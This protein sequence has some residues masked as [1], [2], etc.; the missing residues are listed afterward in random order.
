MKNERALFRALGLGVITAIVVFAVASCETGATTDPIYHTVMFY[1]SGGSVI[2]P[3]QVREGQPLAIPAN[4]TRGYDVFAGWYTNAEFTERFNQATL[5]TGPI[6]LF[7]RWGVHGC[8]DAGCSYIDCECTG[9]PGADCWC[10]WTSTG[11]KGL[12]FTRSG[13]GY[14]VTGFTGT[15]TDVVIPPIHNE[16]AVVAIWNSAFYENHLINIIIP[17]SVI[18]IGELAFSGNLLTSVTIPGSVTSIGWGA[19]SWNQLTSVTIPD[20]VTSIGSRAFGFNRL[21]NVT[22]SDSVTHLSGFTG[23][24]LTS[25]TIPD[26]VTS[27]GDAA[28]NHNQ[29]TSVTIPDGV[30]SIGD[31]AFG[32]NLLTSVTIPDSVTSIGVQA[33]IGNTLTSIT[34]PGN[35]VIADD[36]MGTHGS[37]F[38]ALY[39]GNGRLAGTYIFASGVWTLQ[40]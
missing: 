30:T 18:Y 3:V 35:V 11:T 38:L 13:A 14:A 19:F 20:G 1:T 24:Q 36:A 5:V 8:D 10:D 31:A 34:I 9:C 22:I 16:L 17:G 12:V 39:N 25:V 7:A 26:S 37:S 4:P 27:I 15:A 23:N 6:I 29:L 21:T 28:F 2:G 40:Q 32:F 33:F